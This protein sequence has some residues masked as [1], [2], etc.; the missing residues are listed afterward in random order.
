MGNYS[1][2]SRQDRPGLTSR[3][4]YPVDIDRFE[5]LLSKISPHLS[6]RL[7]ESQGATIEIEFSTLDDFHPDTLYKRLSF[8][9]TLRKTRENLLNPATAADTLAALRGDK[10][11]DKIEPVQNDSEESD[12]EMFERL[13]GRKSVQQESRR[14]VAQSAAEQFI[15]NTIQPYIVDSTDPQRQTYID[16]IDDAIGSEMRRLLH[17]PA[18]QALESIW[19]SLYRLV[20]GLETGEELELYLL[21]LTKQELLEDLTNSENRLENSVL[22][23]LLQGP[24]AGQQD[25]T[26]WSVMAADFS[27]GLSTD[28]QT[29]LKALGAL[30]ARADSPFLAAA[31]PEIL[32]CT[33][34]ADKPNHQE[35]QPL[36]ERMNAQ[37]LA[38]RNSEHAAWIGL[39]LPRILLRLPYGPNTDE[40]ESFEFTELPDPAKSHEDFLWGSPAFAC[41]ILLALAYLQG[42]AAM[43]PG[44]VLAIEDLP[45]FTFDTAEG[46]ELMPCAE[47]WLSE[48]TGEAILERGVMPFMSYRNRNFTRLLQFRSVALPATTLSGFWS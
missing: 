44:D 14:T 43:Q 48:A 25:Q 22:F 9:Q 37:W 42:G 6:F 20:S 45:A 34:L 1:G 29:L 10:P 4:I 12:G 17:N 28:D 3:K 11:I 38:L 2:E 8:F 35:W 23:Q 32:G 13:L 16:S 31:S 47:T 33:S 40:I 46:K 15:Q 19:R 24:T 30:A 26:Y 5:P 21:D 27:F 41:V 18:F 7:G 36:D 39:A